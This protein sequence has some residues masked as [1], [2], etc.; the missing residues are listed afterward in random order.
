MVNLT[1]H[2]WYKSFY[3]GFFDLIEQYKISPVLS[4]IT[5]IEFLRG[6]ETFEEKLTLETYMKGYD[7]L[8][9]TQESLDVASEFSSFYNAKF[10]NL[11][12]E[13]GDCVI[14]ADMKKYN[15]SQQQLYL[16]TMNHSDFPRCFFP[17]LGYET[18][19]AGENFQNIGFYSFNEVEYKKSFQEY[20]SGV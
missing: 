7:I 3:K 6:A 5:K 11:K 15:S 18:I 20:T 8:P 19:E 16:A 4:G 17:R 13:F 1:G 9:F 12:I 14:A 2:E 10:K